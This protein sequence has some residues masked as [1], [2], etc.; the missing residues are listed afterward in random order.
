MIAMD[1]ATLRFRIRISLYLLILVATITA[2][3]IVY[4]SQ[5]DLNDYRI[6]LE[7]KLTATLNQPVH[8]G[9]CKLTFSR[10]IAIALDDLQIGADGDEIAIVP[11]I[12]AT[13]KILPLLQRQ[14]ILDHVRA[15]TPQLTLHLPILQQSK[16]ASKSL[17][18]SLGITT[19]NVQNGNLTIY[20]Q[21]KKNT[22]DKL[23]LANINIT[24]KGWNPGQIGHLIVNGK[25]EKYDSNFMLETNLPSSNDP[26]TWRSEEV[27]TNLQI[28]NFPLKRLLKIT[29]ENIPEKLELNLSVQ[30]IPTTGAHFNLD[31]KNATNQAQVFTLAGDWTSKQ[32][33]EALTAI[34]GDFFD[35]P[36]NGE[37]NLIRKADRSILTG[38]LNVKNFTLTAQQLKEWQIPNNDKFITGKLDQLIL[39]INHN[40]GTDD[41]F[42]T[43][44]INLNLAV[45]ALNW[46]LPKFKQLQE[47]AVNLKLKDQTLQIKNG[48]LVGA[49]H[50]FFFSGNITSLFQ[51][52]QVN[53]ELNFSAQTSDIATFYD[54]PEGWEISGIAPGAI[55]LSGSLY[56][57]TITLQ[58]DL[59]S[60]NANMGMLFN[61][62]TT[63]SSKIYL[64]GHIGKH[65]YQLNKFIFNLNDFNLTA[66]GYYNSNGK[67]TDYQLTTNQLD[68]AKLQ[69]FSLLLQRIKL[70]G[71][72]K[73]EIAPQDEEIAATVVLNNGGAHIISFLG[74]ITNTNGTVNLNKRGFTFKQLNTSLGQSP[75]TVDGVFT[76][77]RDPLLVLDINGKKVRA[78]DIVF[79][80]QQLT[81]HDLTGQLQIDA[82]SIHFTPINVRLE[83]NTLATVKGEINFSHP[84]VDFDISAEQADI[85]D[86]IN[87]FVNKEAKKDRSVKHKGAPLNI[88]IA[89]KEGHIGGLH[90][91]NATGL[92]TGDKDQLTVYPLK[93]E[94]GNGWCE[95]LIIFDYNDTIAPLRISGHA[96]DIDA[97]AVHQNVFEKRG[98]I[99]GSLNGDFHIEGNPATNTHF[100]NTAK[101][102]ISIQIKDDTLR[103]FHG[104][105]KVFSLLNVS[106]IFSGK[107]PDMNREGMPFNL[108]EGSTL[109]GDG[110][111]K[112]ESLKVT[113]VAMNLSIVGTHNFTNNTLDITLGVMPLRTVDKIIS[114]IP[115]AGWILT[116]EDKALITAHFKIEGDSEHPKVSAIPI[117]SVSETVLGIFKRTFGLPGKVIDMFTPAPATKS[118]K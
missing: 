64:S 13:L 96:E 115:L 1:S 26:D 21:T 67:E 54:L 40:W 62:K 103:K 48:T 10:G 58:A 91:K 60:I 100:W 69:P 109:I 75:F 83:D 42:T 101:G 49:N 102:K 22:P 113:S 70:T 110:K 27:T 108:I 55:N 90:F 16:I 25:L 35:L 28:A 68:F 17:F 111:A 107:L 18:S 43:P 86:I 14:F 6:Y 39:S 117:S 82:Q 74:D 46:N 98:L 50:S 92:I 88:K 81:F 59:S 9:N 56:D 30:G 53:L 97:S 29:H 31:I 114:A 32:Q 106:Q 79:A 71:T 87:L 85:L 20:R 93:F 37:F 12:T 65:N 34:H 51:Q 19:L 24:L 4:I 72:A 41:G 116:G 63:D 112:I 3:G 2:S 61:K 36:L 8:I 15:N 57:P 5:I 77:W 104:L 94:N 45:S 73:A 76:N 105:A 52:P 47:L 7:N 78:Q 44:D 80:N 89:V 23:V 118:D 11:Y 95:P 99:S 33:Q 38:Q 66:N 84:V